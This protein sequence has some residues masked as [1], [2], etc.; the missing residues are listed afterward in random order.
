MSDVGPV[1]TL[2]LA[3]YF[4][5]LGATGFGG[6]VALV[7]YMQRDLVERRAWFTE[8]E[9]ADGLALA[10]V[11][12][13]PLAA[14][15]AM[16]LG[17]RRGGVGGATLTAVAFVA[18]PFAMVLAI[19]VLYV[20]AGELAWLR[21]AFVGVG[22]GVVCIL[23]RST[24]KLARLTLYRERLLWAI[25]AVN[26]GAVLALQR[27]SV[28]LLAASG[29]AVLAAR[30]AWRP[31][32]LLAAAPW[33]A[34]YASAPLAGAGALELFVFFAQ[35]GAAVFGSGLAIV[36]FLYTG[37]VEQR[38]WL[39]E[40]QFLDAIAVSMITPGPVVITATFIG[41][42]VG[43]VLGACVAALG[44][45]L[46]AYLVVLLVAPRFAAI[47]GNARVRHVVAGV[48]A[49]ATGAIAG[50]AILLSSRVLTDARGLAIAAV[51]LVALLSR[52]K[53]PEPLLIAG[54]GLL[55]IALGS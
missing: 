29:A 14:Q 43:G 12:P 39:T 51:V 42:L 55:G 47:V 17:W 10:Q 34:T 27:E 54:A 19:A 6:P 32:P 9:F 13:G 1:S 35:A 31:T 2:A 15:L 36:P 40:R 53:L 21:D 7:G 49:G 16:Y 45:F 25:A 28:P 33:L 38:H 46:P 24:V 20:R 18:P 4:L 48:T 30:S 37:L 26:A 11:S 52:T 50:A 8:G 5:G 41:Y 44:V 22:A 23:A 3:R